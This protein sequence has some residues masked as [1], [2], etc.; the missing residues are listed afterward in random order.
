MASEREL[1]RMRARMRA[2]VRDTVHARQQRRARAGNA[3][4]SRLLRVAWAFA[5][6][7]AVTLALSLIILATAYTSLTR[8]LPSLETLPTLLDPPDGLLLQPTRLYDRSGQT[9]LHTL[10]NSAVP[11][12]QYLPLE[13]LPQTLKDATLAS[14][15]SVTPAAF[16]IFSSAPLSQNLVSNLLLWNEPPGLRRDFRLALLA[17]QLERAYGPDQL[18]EWYLNSASYGHLAYGVD[19]AARTYL[20]KSAANLTLPEAALLAAVAQAPDLNPF[21]T[22]ELA[23]ERRQDILQTMRAQGW[24][25]ETEIRTALAAPLGTL[26]PPPEQPTRDA[27]FLDLVLRELAPHLPRARLERGGFNIL[28]TLDADLQAQTACAIAA[29][30]AHLTSRETPPAECEAARLLPTVAL[31]PARDLSGLSAQAAVLDPRAGQILALTGLTLTGSGLQYAAALAPHSP[32]TLLAPYV[33]LTAFTRGFSPASLV[34]DIPASLPAGFAQNPNP[35]GQYHGPQRMRL[36]LANDYLI[37]TLALLRELGPETVWKTASQL[38]LPSL[39][40]PPRAAGATS[41]DPA[42]SLLLEGGDLT[43]LEIAQAYGVFSTQGILFGYA[44]EDR[45]GAPLL[46]TTLLRVE[47][48][49]G[50]VWYAP[51][52]PDARPV[53]S[54]QLAYL[55]THILSDEAARWPSLGHP[56]AL[57]IGRPAG[58]KLGLTLAGRAAW[59]VGFTPQLVT[60][61]WTGFEPDPG[62]ETSASP[63]SSTPAIPKEIPATLWHAITKYAVRNLPAE[64]WPVPPGI[65]VIEVCDPSGQLPTPECPATVREIFTPGSEPTQADTL[66]RRVQ[67][68]RETGLLAT[69]FTPPELIEERVYLI[70]PPEAAEWAREAGLPT[71]PESYDLVSAPAAPNPDARFDA[72]AMFATVGGQV[73]VEGRASGADFQS[74]Q[75][76][77][78]QGLNPQRWTLIGEQSN[79]PVEGGVLAVWDTTGLNGLYALRLLV[80]R[81]DQRIDTAVL[82]VTVDNTLPT[83]EIIFPTEGQSFTYL[84]DDRITIQFNARDDLALAQ[85][86]LFLNNQR[87]GT[88][89]Q[90]PYAF[91]W[92]V[93]PGEHTIRVR[94][95]DLAGNVGEVRITFVVER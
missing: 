27:A 62:E 80:I 59:A 63:T 7:A 84:E 89:T 2:R 73:A 15:S 37:P 34:W 31:D 54:A 33:Y 29:Q 75:V 35:D 4:Q 88:F 21:D 87:L 78:G 66:F 70:P 11:S 94:A 43:L 81:T 32:G 6:A 22:P 36:A 26:A 51:G 8:D 67:I 77:V 79:T 58:A 41:G 69:V 86:E 57:E 53:I 49:A 10:Q 13:Q 9:V 72:P 52:P 50:R 48:L 90:P 1:I 76:Q 95:T 30:L 47:D 83:A 45:P 17:A 68:N 93:L 71:P 14:F 46:L 39:T 60:A 44:K 28:T 5:A 40:I 61:I 92:D 82:Q 12:R 18:L 65:S 38:G 20:G 56:N 55:L 25:S 24:I 16:P 64:T 85:V 3:T 74:Y 23:L 19:A 42:L 91:S